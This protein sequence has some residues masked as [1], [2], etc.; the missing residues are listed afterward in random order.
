M[1]INIKTVIECLKIVILIT[2]CKL[3]DFKMAVIK[4]I[5]NQ[6]QKYLAI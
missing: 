1:L 4:F 6:F 2:I 3:I 5:K